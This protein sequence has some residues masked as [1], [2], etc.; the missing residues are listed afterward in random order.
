MDEGVMRH[1]A[2]RTGTGLTLHG[3]PSLRL[4]EDTCNAPGE[5]VESGYHP[6]TGQLAIPG[7]QP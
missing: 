7:R 4:A 1:A 5:S 3:S 6:H 2:A